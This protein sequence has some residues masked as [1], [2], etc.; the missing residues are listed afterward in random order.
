M[1]WEKWYSLVSVVS[2]FE[3]ETFRREVSATIYL[4]T[5]LVDYISG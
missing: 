2:R 5:C 4:L 1:M 3:P